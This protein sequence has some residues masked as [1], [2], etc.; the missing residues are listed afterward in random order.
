MVPLL[1]P[2]R[3]GGY[4]KAARASLGLLCT[5]TLLPGPF[6]RTPSVHPATAGRAMAN[7]GVKE[8]GGWRE[9]EE[10][11]RWLSGRAATAGCDP[12]DA[13]LAA[14]L[15]AFDLPVAL[16]LLSAQRSSG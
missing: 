4:L 8:G 9:Q 16:P 2:T 12:L 11:E 10:A 15:G 7:T 6:L 5:C 13:A 1:L 14:H 3:W